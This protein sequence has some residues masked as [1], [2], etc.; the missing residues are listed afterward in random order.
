MKIGGNLL[1]DE[2][3]IGVQFHV[4]S[5]SKLSKGFDPVET[6]PTRLFRPVCSFPFPLLF[7]DADL[8]DVTGAAGLGGRGIL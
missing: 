1:A 8:F 7:L 2:S 3:V 4:D 6:C 5:V